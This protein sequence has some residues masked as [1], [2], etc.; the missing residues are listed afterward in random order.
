MCGISGTLHFDGKPIDPNI[1]RRMTNIISHRGPD[2]SGDY[3]TGPIG[4]GHRRLA[5]IDISSAAKQP[6]P[7]EDGSVWIVCNGEIY[8]F[9]DLRC[10]LVKKGHIFRSAS[11]TETIVHAYEEWGTDCLRH[12]NGMFGFGLWDA[13]K[14]LLWLVRD[15]IGVKP[16]FYSHSRSFLIFGSEIKAILFYPGINR[17]L[18]Y[19]ALAY[20]LA[21]NYTP[22]PFTLFSGINQLL[23]GHYLIV[24]KKGKIQ[25]VEY[26]DLVF[27]VNNRRDKL[28][29]I[30]EFNDLLQ[31]SVRSRLISDVPF[32]GLS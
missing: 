27:E 25:D 24:D 31:D 18:N 6:M 13:S 32:G 28:F 30:K 16:L 9:L 29:Y 22:A 12:L 3:I 11:D 15:R 5:I 8:N 14:Q 7:N 4:L 23:P 10:T 17:S 2:D 20:Y 21:L 26:W 1:L 19:E